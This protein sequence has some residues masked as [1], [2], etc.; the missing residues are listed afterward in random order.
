MGLALSRRRSNALGFLACVGMLG[1]ALYTQRFQGLTPCNMCILQR[2]AVGFL[3]A[4][5]LLAF[6]HHP[7][8]PWGRLYAG[9]IAVAALPG[10]LLSARQVW[11]Q[12]QPAGSLPSCGADFYALL[13]FLSPAD[14][15][16]TVWRGGGDCQA[17]TWSLF[18]LSMAGWVLICVGCLAAF[19]LRQNWSRDPS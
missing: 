1:F 4:A 5:F 14:A 11:M 16:L 7:R 6:L 9:V 10:L 18:G 19:G 2:F 17:V 3:G 15:V 13:S 12:A 8:Q